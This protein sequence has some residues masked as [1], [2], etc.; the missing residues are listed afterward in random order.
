LKSNAAAFGAGAMFGIGLAI[1]GMTMP[2][3]VI[4][5]LDFAGRWD[6]SLLFVMAG[7]VGVHFLAHRVLAKR[8]PLFAAK[9]D[10]PTRRDLDKRLLAGAAIFGVGWGLAGFCPGPAIVT[11]ASGELTA[12]VFVVG[13]LLGIFAEKAILA[14]RADRRPTC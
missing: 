9:H 4:G 14:R 13:M 1:S 10:L 3:K 11:A 2:S 5:F 7:A 8:K 12:I 6:A